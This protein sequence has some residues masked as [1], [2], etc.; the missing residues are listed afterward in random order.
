M[1]T[2]ILEEKRAIELLQ[3]LTEEITFFIG[4]NP[5][6]L[7][8]F[9]W[10]TFCLI[11]LTVFL[12]Q[13]K[14]FL[15]EVYSQK[16]TEKEVLTE[17]YDE[18]SEDFDDFCFVL[19]KI[20]P[21]SLNRKVELNQKVV[22]TRNSFEYHPQLSKGTLGNVVGIEDEACSMFIVEF[23]FDKT[24][25]LDSEITFIMPFLILEED[26]EEKK[27]GFRGKN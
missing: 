24:Y 8:R 15:T 16:E 17:I 25:S 5:K 21:P 11:T 6:L 20:L 2:E 12:Y 1:F 10:F 26:A 23:F 14:L 7:T 9:A 4:S 19:A 3:L 22:V 18:A 13:L 27:S